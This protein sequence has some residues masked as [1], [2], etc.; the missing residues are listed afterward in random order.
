MKHINVRI[1]NVTVL[2][3]V[4]LH[5]FYD[6]KSQEQ[7]LFQTQK[8]NKLQGGLDAR[9]VEWGRSYIDYLL[10]SWC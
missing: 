7:A 5:T 1:C 3:V 6:M 10:C 8:F 2:S 9:R 4:N